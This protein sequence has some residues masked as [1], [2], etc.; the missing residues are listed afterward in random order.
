MEQ[1]LLTIG[2]DELLN[3]ILVEK[4]VRPAML[5]QPAD[6]DEATYK[7]AKTAAKLIAIKQQFPDLIQSI[8]GGGEIIISKHKISPEDITENA[9]MGKILGYPCYADYQYT[10]DNKDAIKVR[11]E[12]IVNLKPGLNNDNLQLLAYVCRDERFFAESQA[13]A[14]NCV[15]VLKADPLVG[16][17]ID[18]VSAKKTVIMPAKYLINKLVNNEEITQ[19]E[20]GEIIDKIWNLGFPEKEGGKVIKINYQFQNPVHRGMIIALLTVYDNNQMKPFWPLQYRKEHRQVDK[21]SVAWAKE[22]IRT[23]R[24]TESADGAGLTRKTRRNRRRPSVSPL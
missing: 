22:L 9:T 15:D 6:Y 13:F 24:E 17:L 12:I 20:K 10:L 21:I 2:L 18:S 5:I 11:I 3:C 23:F 7:D 19:S 14:K 16:K 1:H 4:D 8:V